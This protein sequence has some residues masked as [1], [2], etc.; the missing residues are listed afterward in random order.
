M[1][2][3][4]QTRIQPTQQSRWDML[5]GTRATPDQKMH[6]FFTLLAV[7]KK[8][9]GFVNKSAELQKNIKKDRAFWDVFLGMIIRATNKVLSQEV[10]RFWRDPNSLLPHGTWLTMA[11]NKDRWDAR[12]L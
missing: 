10:L 5:V 6:D 12:I 8:C 7:F 9:K 2:L 4:A 3:P 11:G 1:P